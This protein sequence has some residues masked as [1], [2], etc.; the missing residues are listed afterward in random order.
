MNGSMISS[1]P[2]FVC[3]FWSVLL[4]LD[5]AKNRQPAKRLLLVCMVAATLLY[6]GHYIYFNRQITLLPYSDT[7]YCTMN[8]A[9]FPLYYLYITQLTQPCQERCRRWLWLLP[10]VTIGLGV[11][12]LYAIMTPD[13]TQHFIISYL[14]HN[15]TSALTGL[16][17][18]QWGLHL[19]AKTV[20]ALQ[21]LPILILGFRKISKYNEAVEDYYADTDDKSLHKMKYVLVAFVLTSLL[22]LLAN[23]L[24]RAHFASSAW[25][26]AIPSILF[27]VLLFML[28]YVGYIQQF[29]MTDMLRDNASRANS[30]TQPEAHA[31]AQP[32]EDVIEQ[33]HRQLLE[34]VDDNELFLRSDLKISHLADY[35][36]TNRE[37]L[38]Q[39]L[40][41]RMGVTFSE[42]I[43]RHRINHAIS[44][45]KQ[46]PELPANDVAQ[47]SGYSSLASFYRNFKA[48]EGC[49]P[50]E[51]LKQQQRDT[52]SLSEKN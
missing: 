17:R 10:S 41:V 40:N 48:F 50:K 35:Y 9:V 15:D 6:I 26:L 43:N 1:I 21:I 18:W 49:S 8:L 52:A 25:P 32:E 20:F 29:S 51:F 16:S 36:H 34:D 14:Y 46:S 4:L 37:Y 7:V 11:G 13:E 47:Q 5:V 12:V 28:A 39:A 42:F 27:S 44:L 19:L 23:A 24:G 3:A 33:L 31:D 38:Y 2:M 45:M 30:G 22:S